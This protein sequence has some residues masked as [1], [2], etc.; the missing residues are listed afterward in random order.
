MAK[1]ADA[2]GLGPCGE[3]LGGSSPLRPTNKH[4]NNTTLE[5]QPD[6]T[7][8]LTITVPL[9]AIKK[10][11]IEV[12]AE[13]TKTAVVAGFRPGKAPTSMA[14][15]QI[16]PDKLNEEII[17]KILPPAYA[18]AIQANNL[19]P[20]MNP[21]I[22]IEKLD[23][24]KDLLFTAATCE[25]PKIELGDYR[26]NI[27]KL[28]AASKIIIPGKESKKPN[29]EEIMKA[30]VNDIKIAIPKI[31]IEQEA[32][33]LLAQLLNDIK[34]LGLNLDQYLSSTNRTPEDIRHLFLY[35]K[36]SV[37]VTAYIAS[38]KSVN[39]VIFPP[40]IPNPQQLYDSCGILWQRLDSCIAIAG[41]RRWSSP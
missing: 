4:M 6:G 28:T 15:E 1:L 17:K 19:K 29:S 16:N 41:I 23:P 32:D 25:E 8:K 21:K 12:I 9:E 13:Y 5:R 10:A 7:I 11:R 27:K 20:I 3:T 39:L 34:K 31:L 33:R 2:H 14:E 38:L 40:Y 36:A 26:K 24:L 22:H 37:F 18:Q 30:V 35:F